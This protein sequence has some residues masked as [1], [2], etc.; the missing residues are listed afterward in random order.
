MQLRGKTT[1]PVIETRKPGRS[2][3]LNVKAYVAFK[4]YAGFLVFLNSCLL[5]MSVWS[6]SAM[7]TAQITKK[8]ERMENVMEIKDLPLFPL[9]LYT[10]GFGFPL[11][12]TRDSWVIIA[13]PFDVKEEKQ[14]CNI[15]C[16]SQRWILITSWGVMQKGRT[17]RVG[18]LFP[19]LLTRGW[20]LRSG[21]LIYQLLEQTRF[22][23]N[24]TTEHMTLKISWRKCIETVSFWLLCGEDSTL[25]LM[26]LKQDEINWSGFVI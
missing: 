1:S 10:W 20:P 9:Y 18:Q 7:N 15:D 24:L 6:A 17:H 4:P 2:I 5:Q 14:S 8:V 16:L 21:E 11:R 12:K 22:I 19:Q 25:E 13:F 3:D 26:H 23:L